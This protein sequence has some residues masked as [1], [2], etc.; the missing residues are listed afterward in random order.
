L[1]LSGVVLLYCHSNEGAKA[2][3]KILE[4]TP[5]VGF[6]A[7][8]KVQTD[9]IMERSRGFKLGQAVNEGDTL[10]FTE[11]AEKKPEML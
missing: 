6:D 10:V 9:P 4:R 5:V 1:K 8:L 7:V 3:S 11:F 2:V